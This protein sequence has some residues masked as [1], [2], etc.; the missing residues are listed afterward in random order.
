MPILD[1][2]D[3]RID[4]ASADIGK[5]V[6]AQRCSICHGPNAL[7]GGAAPDLLRSGVAADLE[8]FSAVLREG[9]LQSRGMPR[10][11]ELTDA[12]LKGLQHYLRSRARE[13]AAAPPV[14]TEIRHAEGQ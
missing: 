2:P 5:T 14:P 9:P 3:F 13:V 10:F 12:E 7:S 8:S 1:L 6:Y 4:R 11:E